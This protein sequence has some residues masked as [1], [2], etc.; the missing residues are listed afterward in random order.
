MGWKTSCFEIGSDEPSEAER[1]EGSS[2]LTESSWLTYY[3]IVNGCRHCDWQTKFLVLEFVWLSR[4][5]G[6]R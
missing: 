5:F 4:A 6:R 2:S 1:R 3:S